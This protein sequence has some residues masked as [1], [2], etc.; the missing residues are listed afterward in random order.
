ML[1][2]D[3]CK[4]VVSRILQAYQLNTVKALCEKWDITP[5][6]IASRI[7][8]N[9]L[10]A[11]IVLR[12]TIETGVNA[13]WL[14]TG[15]GEPGIEGFQPMKKIV[16]SDD[17]LEKLERLTALKEKGSITEQEFNLLKANLIS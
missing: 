14:L 15:E 3:D 10:P 1:N 8:R 17:V 7:Q 16:F 6:V 12:C 2:F 11:D 4:S 5:S 13:L 9:T